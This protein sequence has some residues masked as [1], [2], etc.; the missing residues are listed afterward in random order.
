MRKRV[1]AAS[2]AGAVLA[3]AA[4]AVAPSAAPGEGGPNAPTSPVS[5]TTSR[6]Q[7]RH[8]HTQLRGALAGRRASENSPTRCSSSTRRALRRTRNRITRRHLPD[9]RSRDGHSSH[10]RAATRLSAC[11]PPPRART[12]TCIDRAPN[13]GCIQIAGA[14]CNGRRLR[15]R[16]VRRAP[17]PASA[18]RGPVARHR[19]PPTLSPRARA[20]VRPSAKRQARGRAGQPPRRAPPPRR[21]SPSAAG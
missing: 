20:T 15:L 9:I 13:A 18:S 11:M 5:Y 14:A 6:R 4:F 8:R 12:V 17:G 7:G 1:L 19:Q 16:V 10:T 21:P 2:V 3:I